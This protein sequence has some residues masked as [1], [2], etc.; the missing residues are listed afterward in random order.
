MK[1]ILVTGGLG[2]IG[3]NISILLKASGYDITIIDSCNE[4]SGYN[5]YHEEIA[6]KNGIRVIKDSIGNISRHADGIAGTEC[7]INLAA[8][9]SHI[10]SINDPLTDIENNTVE[11]VRFIKS[12]TDTLRD[13]RIIF[14]STRQIYGRQPSLPVNENTCV[15]PVDANGINKYAAELYHRVFTDIT[16]MDLLVLRITNVY[17]PYMYIRDKRLSFIGWFLNRMLNGQDIEIYGTGEQKR[18]MLYVEDL[19]RT[20]AGAVESSHTGIYNISGAR[21]HSLNE[22][23]GLCREISGV[24]IKR[25]AFPENISRIDIGSFSA[26][27]ELAMRDLGHDPQTDLKNGLIKTIE[28]YKGHSERYL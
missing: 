18:D 23:A 1:K 5:K 26:S 7:I 24:N 20:I 9:I 21:T 19:C 16:G 11:H 22:I 14:A 10:D 8:L 25:T 15:N 3:I 2:F 27:N 6:C 17:G 4:K 12:V 13:V 28:Y